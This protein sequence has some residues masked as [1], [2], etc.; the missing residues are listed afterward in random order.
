MLLQLTP[1]R[2]EPVPP[3]YCKASSEPCRAAGALLPVR[4]LAAAADLAADGVP[5][6]PCQAPAC[7]KRILT[8]RGATLLPVMAGG[9]WRGIVLFMLVHFAATKSKVAVRFPRFR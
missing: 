7:G 9:A 8:H 1:G 2:R 4:L 6:M 3:V 5:T